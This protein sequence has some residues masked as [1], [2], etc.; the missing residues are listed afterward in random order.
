MKNSIRFFIIEVISMLSLY[1]LGI[2]VGFSLTKIGL[3]A[4][5]NF[6]NQLLAMLVVSGMSNAVYSWRH[7]F[8]NLY[9][10]T[11]QTILIPIL[12]I[13]LLIVQMD[14]MS[15]ELRFFYLNVL[16]MVYTIGSIFSLGPKIGRKVS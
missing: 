4:L 7:V 2:S 16:L 6:F 11:K 13:F 12:I 10:Y 8:H 3:L 5:L 9:I 15:I 1:L 14:T